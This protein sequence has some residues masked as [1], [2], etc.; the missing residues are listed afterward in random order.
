MRY[1]ALALLPLVLTACNENTSPGPDREA[2][3]AA[4]PTPSAIASAAEA[5]DGIATESVTVEPMTS[6][7]IAALGEAAGDCRFVMTEVAF[8]SLAYEPGVRATIKLNGKLII[9]PA[10]GPHSYEEGPLRVL[11]RPLEGEGDAGLPMEEMI[12]L[13]PGAEDERGY[14]GYRQCLAEGEA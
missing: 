7:D 2:Q 12:V 11:L 8:P 10:T 1:A 5:L 9:M 13:L 3:L 4:A 14:R 6:A